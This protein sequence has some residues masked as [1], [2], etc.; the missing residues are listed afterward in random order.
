LKRSTTGKEGQWGEGEEEGE[1]EGEVVVEEEDLEALAEEEDLE[2]A[3]L[4]EEEA[5]NLEENKVVVQIRK[6]R[7]NRRQKQV[8]TIRN[9]YW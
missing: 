6:D 5:A 2:A 3:S 4:V 1:E 8:V 9:R 7:I